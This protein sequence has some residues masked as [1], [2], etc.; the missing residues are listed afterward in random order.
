[1]MNAP[2]LKDAFPTVKTIPPVWDE[3]RVLPGSEIG[4]LS[5]MAR[6]SGDVWFVGVLNGEQITKDYQLDLTF[7]GEGNYLITTV[8]DDLKSDRVNLVGLN[9]KADLHE[10]TTA[11]PLKVKKRSLTREKTLDIKLAPG[12]GFVARFTKI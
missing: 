4:K 3:T 12:G 9:A 7:L 8:S 11:I 6:R 1:M 10:F 2:I 5:S